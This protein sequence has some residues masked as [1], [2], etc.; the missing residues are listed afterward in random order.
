MLVIILIIS[1]IISIFLNEIESTIVIFVVLTIN[2]CLGTYQYQ[3]AQ[4]SLNSLKNLSSP[5]CYVLRNNEI[6][7]IKS[8]EL[9]C[10][11]IV[12]V[13][14]GD[15]I[16]ADGRI[17]EEEG[18][19]INESS[20]TGESISVKKNNE[21]IKGD[22]ELIE[23]KNMLFSGTSCTKGQG[24]YIVCNTG[25][26]TEI[27]KIAAK[28]NS[29]TASKTPLEENLNNFSKYLSIIILVVCGVIFLINFYRHGSFLDSLMFA[30]ALAVAAIPEALS[31]IV[32]IVL[33]L[34]TEKMAKENAIIKDIKSVESLGCIS[35]IC[36]DKTGVLSC[37]SR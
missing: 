33:A 27:G 7:K 32:T 16:S 2:A 9:V 1:A 31:T 26:N 22:C 13:N 12:V 19:E 30:V 37:Y 5:V 10:G 6:K 28:L 24:K 18:L 20:L 35:V 14:T 29:I 36:T 17:I 21:I 11:D 23:Q 15:V 3:K 34:G 25:I 4:K 8:Y